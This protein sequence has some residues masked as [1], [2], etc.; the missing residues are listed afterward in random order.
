[1]GLFDEA[2]IMNAPA[3]H[4]RLN[5]VSHSERLVTAAMDEVHDANLARLL[6]H[7]VMYSA[8]A[9]LLAPVPR[10]D[11]DIALGRALRRHH[12]NNA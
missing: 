8:M 9:H 4:W 3:D 5:I 10:R 6:V 1:L 11:L 2:L 12:A 7:G